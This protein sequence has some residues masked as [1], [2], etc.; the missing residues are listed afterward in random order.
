MYVCRELR[1]IFASLRERCCHGDSDAI[2]RQLISSCI[3]LRFICA[4]ILSP[5]LFGLVQT[6]PQ[7]RV[8]RSLTLIAKTIQ[9]LANF[10]RW[11]T[12][13]S[14]R[15][16]SCLVAKCHT[17]IIMSLSAHDLLLSHHKLR[18]SA[19]TVLSPQTVCKCVST[20]SH[21]VRMW[22]AV[23]VHFLL[24]LLRLLPQRWPS[25]LTTPYT[26]HYILCLL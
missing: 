16:R 15:R 21:G 3:F 5:S 17:R 10:T 12:H 11:V 7:Q 24:V 26:I 13:G 8:L 6:L 19:V 23:F 1:Q 20:Q 2:G 9:G 14:L 18:P 25:V 22:W 4:A